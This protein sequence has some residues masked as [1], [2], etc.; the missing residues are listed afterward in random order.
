ML[1]RQI[2]WQVMRYRHLAQD[3]I[4]RWGRLDVLV[5]NASLFHPT[6]IDSIDDSVWNTMLGIHIKAPCS[7]V[8]LLTDE[9]RRQRGCIINITD[10]H[11]DRP[12]KNYL[13][14]STAKA[15]LVALTKALA[16]ELAPE[17]RCNAVA[18]GA[19][20]WPEDGAHETQH[21]AIIARTALQREGC[22]QD[23]VAA[24]LFLIRYADYIT[25]QTINVDGGRTLAN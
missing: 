5:N 6:P 23:I 25:G 17:I 20:L 14:Y 3:S 7:L 10:I 11:T 15:G 19:I 8:Q 4:A 21:Q 16:R 13:A 1:F 12:L 9:L 24:V 18:P 22:P 2:C